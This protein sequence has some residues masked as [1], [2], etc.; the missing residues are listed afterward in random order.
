ML[1]LAS[2]PGQKKAE[3]PSWYYDR[4]TDGKYDGKLNPAT[5]RGL[6]HDV[7]HERL[8]E[9]KS[10]YFEAA[11]VVQY[12][13]GKDAGPINPDPTR[14]QLVR[15]PEHE[16]P[17]EAA[18]MP[19]VVR[20]G[21]WMLQDRATGDLVLDA[22]VYDKAQKQDPGKLLDEKR[23]KEEKYPGLKHVT[24]FFEARG[25]YGSRAE[26]QD[27]DSITAEENPQAP[28][29]VRLHTKTRRGKTPTPPK[30]LTKKHQKEETCD[31]EAH[32]SYWFW[33]VLAGIVL[34]AIL[35]LWL[36]W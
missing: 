21:V 7:F 25:A 9:Q 22:G 13:Y 15:S 30:R 24:D 34:V 1:T 12:Q 14:Y 23:E 8:R 2:L 5:H 31:K 26:Q 27:E 19:S 20:K 17:L 33:W 35:L 36:V 29:A 16:I 10:L 11:Q 32:S 3:E 28:P 4:E 6:A 18:M